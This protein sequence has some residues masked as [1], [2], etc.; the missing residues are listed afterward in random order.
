[1]SLDKSKPG[2]SRAH[3]CGVK[4]AESRRLTVIDCSP[5]GGVSVDSTSGSEVRI[6]WENSGDGR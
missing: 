6:N 3:I 2:A 1:M 4:A 5:S